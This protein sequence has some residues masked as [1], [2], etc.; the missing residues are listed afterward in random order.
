[1]KQVD[2]GDVDLSMSQ[3]DNCDL[4][5]AVFNRSIIEKADFRTARNY[6]IDPEQNKVKQAKFSALGLAGLLDKYNLIIEH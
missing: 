3:F 5:E 1:M 6:R 4:E 2:F